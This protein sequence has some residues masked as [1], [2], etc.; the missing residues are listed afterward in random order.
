MPTTVP[1]P[2]VDRAAAARVSSSLRAVATAA[3]RVQAWAEATDARHRTERA[4]HPL[5]DDGWD[6]AHDVR[7]PGVDRIDHLAAGPSG[8]YL[9]ASKSWQGVVT[10]DHK[11]ATITP[12]RDQGSAWTARGPHR[13][14]P[15]VAVTVVRALAAATGRSFPPPRAVVVVWAPFP[16]G[17]TVCAGVSYVAGEHL[18]DWLAGQPARTDSPRPGALPRPREPRTTSRGPLRAARP[19]ALGPAAV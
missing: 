7:L 18:A 12:P 17:V 10:V 15:P 1:M 4:L 5:R 6:V 19:R 16:E 3:A 2:R 14:L 13:S 9:L 8:M 11:G